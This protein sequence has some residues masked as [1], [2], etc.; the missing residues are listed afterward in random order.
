M[1]LVP[2]R[3]Y[4][5]AIIFAVS[6]PLTIT[7]IQ[8][9]QCVQRWQRRNS[10]SE[11][12]NASHQV[13]R[14][15]LRDIFLLMLIVGL[16]LAGILHVEPNLPR[17][18]VATYALT[19]A[20]LVTTSVT[21]WVW[22]RTHRRIL[23]SLLLL[24][25]VAAFS[26]AIPCLGNG[27]GYHD[28]WTLLGVGFIPTPLSTPTGTTIPAT[29]WNDVRILA[30]ATGEF[31]LLLIGILALASGRQPAEQSRFAR[32]VRGSMVTLAAAMAI[33]LAAV[34]WQM[35]S[36]APLPPRFSNETTH[37]YRLL[38]VAERMT[39]LAAAPPSTIDELERKAL[40]AEVVTLAQAPNF[41]PVDPSIKLPPEHWDNHPSGRSFFRLARSLTGE[42]SAAVSCGETDR[43]NELALATMRLGV[44]LN[45]GG[46]IPDLIAGNQIEN[47]AFQ[48][49]TEIRRDLPPEQARAVLAELQRA[50]AEHED[51]AAIVARGDAVEERTFGWGIRLQNVVSRLTG[52]Q[53]DYLWFHYEAVRRRTAGT[54]A[55]GQNERQHDHRRCPGSHAEEER[56]PGSPEDGRGCQCQ[57]WCRSSGARFTHDL[58]NGEK[59][60]GNGC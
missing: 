39:A 24:A 51:I 10:A 45:R 12:E 41:V 54:R 5:P 20:A 59:D 8:G 36:L 49:L 16:A 29:L 52:T 18:D 53:P 56:I 58:A 15:G 50:L 57:E 4:E 43:A 48:M 1:A 42:A 47:V 27:P 2:I 38:E 60:R 28:V 33:F 9:I 7:L 32:I 17:F 31:A 19:V 22:T 6:S 30:T 13:I 3:A 23:V 35:L 55:G 25:I 37:Y 34:Y 11:S 21:A 40:I 46:M 44:M 26:F 14:F